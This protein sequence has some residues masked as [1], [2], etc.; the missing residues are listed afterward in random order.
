[1]LLDEKTVQQP[2]WMPVVRI[3]RLGVWIPV[4][5]TKR[6]PDGIHARPDLLKAWIVGTNLSKQLAYRLSVLL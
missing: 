3:Q 2:D 6:I 4:I 1:M 5:T